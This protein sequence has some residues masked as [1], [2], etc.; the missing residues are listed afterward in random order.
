M[1]AVQHA[2]GMH[3]EALF[4]AAFPFAGGLAMSQGTCG[5]VVGG[6]MCLSAASKKYGRPWNEFN[7]WETSQ[8]IEA[9]N[10]VRAVYERCR[11]AMGGTVNC[12]EIVGMDL[13]NEEEAMEYAGSP[14]FETCCKNCGKVARIIVEALLEEA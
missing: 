13:R 8:L 10:H 11:E 3:E 9:L 14:Q 5:A 12:R 2:I 7:R 1:R 4:S 6:I